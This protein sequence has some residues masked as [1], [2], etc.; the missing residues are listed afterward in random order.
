MTD[1]HFISGVSAILPAL[2]LCLVV[3]NREIKE[4]VVIKVGLIAL[5]VSLLVT[6][7]LTVAE[8]RDWGA[9]WRASFVTRA[10][11]LVV[12]LGLFLRA[13]QYSKHTACKVDIDLRDH[14]TMT[15]TILR[16]IYEPVQD[17][18]HLFRADSMPADLDDNV[19]G[20]K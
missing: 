17:L 5:I 15:K 6:F 4:G 9:Y 14:E 20:K 2:A 3:L 1:W 8:S 12:C 11:I 10:S 7:A 19:K 13:R 18:E 16:R